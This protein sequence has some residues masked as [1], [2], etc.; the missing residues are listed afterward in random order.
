MPVEPRSSTTSLPF[1]PQPLPPEKRELAAVTASTWRHDTPA[2]ASAMSTA[3]RHSSVTDFLH[4]TTPRS[5]QPEF[6]GRERLALLVIERVDHEF[7][8]GTD[9]HIARRVDHL[10]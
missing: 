10:A 6:P 7:D 2:S 5:N 4:L 9:A 1:R 8:R 3:C